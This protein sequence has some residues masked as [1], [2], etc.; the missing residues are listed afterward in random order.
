MRILRLTTLLVATSA[1]ACSAQAFGQAGVSNAGNGSQA[2]APIPNAPP[3]APAQ[4]TDAN[5]TAPSATP[6]PAAETSGVQDI[7]VTATRRSANLQT[8][9]LS[10]VA[11]QANTLSAQGL[12]T[13]ADLPRMVP[14]LTTTR[15]SSS[16][17][18]Y[19]RGV[20]SSSS[21]FNNESPVAGYIDGFY[22]PN[23]ASTLFSFNNIERVEV[24][25]GPQ[26]TLYGR[27]AT[28]GLVNVITRNPA[29]QARVD[30]SVGYGNY[31]TLSLNLYASVPLTDT[32][33]AGVAV[34]H[35]DQKDGW[36][37]NIITGNPNMTFRENG[38]NAKIV[39]APAPGTKI[40]L[41]GL[42]THVTTDQGLVDGIYPGS[43]GTDGTPNLGRYVN[44]DTRDGVSD[45][46]LRLV[47]L[48]IEQDLG[49]AKFLSLTGYIHSNA[50]A[51][52]NLSG[53]PGKPVAGQTASNA[54]LSGNSKTFSQ[55]LQL[56]S[57]A[58][59]G[60]RF[61]WI[62]GL[63]YFNDNTTV[64][65][66]VFG[67]CVG[68]VCAA[69]IPTQTTGRPKTRSYAAYAETTYEILPRTRITAGLRYTR[70]EKSLTG[71][72]T[73]LAGFPN[74]PAVLAASTVLH[75]GDPYTG[76]PAGIVTA[77]TF[78]KLTYKAVLAH[79]FTNSIHGYV[80][81]NRGFKSGTFNPTNFTNQPSRPEVLDA[82][83]AG[84][85]SDLFDRLLRLNVS[86]FHY[87][88]K[89]IQVR[90]GAPPAPAGSTITY[91]AAAARVNGVDLEANLVPS[92]HLSINASASYLDGSYTNFTTATCT[93]PR[94]IAGAV[95]GG[96]V[97]AVCNNSG[98]R[99]ANTSRWS[100]NLNAT[101]TLD[102]GV[103]AFALS[104][105]D[106]FKSRSYWDASNR[107]SQNPYHLVSAALTWTSLDKHFD[108][109]AYVRNLT[110]SYYFAN[111]TEATTDVYTPGAPRTFGVNAG[112]HF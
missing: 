54:I 3:A 60:S 7:I 86:G 58:A 22:L 28:G 27:N 10:V 106:S 85:K 21:G 19:L 8:V 31:N 93:T 56:A 72:V 25:K 75:P 12:K 77:V 110:K 40:T 65:N 64:G 11:I 5:P 73:P 43:R 95:L 53:Q 104:A 90:T 52:P 59:A 44:A 16:T 37:K 2:P 81:Y 39:W 108:I 23:T 55:E 42:L 105:N 96:N 89:D 98:H 46:K 26:G 76:N 50:I 30:G 83:E 88:Y 94:P 45:A 102:T 9:P 67:T 32:L 71:D 17:N 61:T 107:L 57:N 1:I 74:T 49:F 80:S 101:Y 92:R 47:G 87:N 111:A 29:Q 18:L 20:G 78:P 97:S 33:S 66:A 99:L 36:G 100:Y 4:A 109:Q 6:D 41:Q 62:G 15:G 82:Y 84:L 69:P 48:R 103:G 35:T 91:N 14:G 34:T 112:F 24:L 63:Y 51:M 70:D 38:A 68:A 79:D 13:I